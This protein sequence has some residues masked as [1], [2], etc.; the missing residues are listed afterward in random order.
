MLRSDWHS[1]EP[2]CM[3]FFPEYRRRILPT[4]SKHFFLVSLISPRH[5]KM[6]MVTGTV[7]DSWFRA[8]PCLGLE[9]LWSRKGHALHRKGSP[10]CFFSRME[11]QGSQHRSPLFPFAFLRM[12]GKHNKERSYGWIAVSVTVPTYHSLGLHIHLC[13]NFLV[14]VSCVRPKDSLGKDWCGRIVCNLSI[15]F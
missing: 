7:S 5:G 14:A 3:F 9:R 8:V 10:L 12:T 11:R 2:F 13:L 15:I 6:W 1:G 4:F